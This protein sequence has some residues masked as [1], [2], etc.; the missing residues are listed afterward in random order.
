MKKIIAIFFLALLIPVVSAQN[1]EQ[2]AGITPDSIFY[3]LDVFLDNVKAILTPSALGK[4]IAR[5][6]IVEERA[7]EMEEMVRENK[8]AEAEKAE[9]EV[10]KQMEKFEMSVEKVKKKDAPELNG[11]IQ[12][13]AGTL[14]ILKQRLGDSDWAEAVNDAIIRLEELENIIVDIPEDLS[15]DSIF[16][17]SQICEEAGAIT[18]AE[19]QEMISSGALT[20]QVRRLPAN[21]TDPHNCSGFWADFLTKTKWCC[22]DSDGRYSPEWIEMRESEGMKGILNYYYRKG[23]VEYKIINL[24][25]EEVEQGIETDSCNGNMLTE[26]LCPRV[27]DMVTK[28]KRYS[29]EYECPNGCQDGAC[30]AE[31]QEPLELPKD[32]RQNSET[33]VEPE[34]CED[35]DGGQDYFVKGT[36]VV[37]FTNNISYVSHY[38]KVDYCIDDTQLREF[39]C[40]GPA[41][42]SEVTYS[43]PNGCQDG[44]CM[45]GEASYNNSG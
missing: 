43:C 41:A 5:L 44:A 1:G 16:I 32:I 38:A 25:T 2:Q 7:A 11:H 4:S 10:Q 26:W 27:M 30:I 45:K 14:E 33:T 21:H 9:L 28:N 31:E 29:E 20:A 39:S 36:V 23:T 34:S 17:I 13:H 18:V 15:P 24:K 37:P 3:G 8:V 12:T 40:E 6:E 42:V 35:S 19:C 22:D